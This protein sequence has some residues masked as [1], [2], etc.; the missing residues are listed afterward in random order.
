[1]RVSLLYMVELSS[2]SKMNKALP[3][4]KARSSGSLYLAR[5]S[6]STC[7]LAELLC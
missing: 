4:T 5:G 1:M 3:V 7:I 6:E 2:G